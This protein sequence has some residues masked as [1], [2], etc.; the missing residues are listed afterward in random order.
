[1]GSDALTT[2]LVACKTDGCGA[3]FCSNTRWAY[4]RNEG[5]SSRFILEGLIP[6]GACPIC[7]QRPSA[8]STPSEGE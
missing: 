7:R 5:T 2:V 3:R 8:P 6:A 4:G 1:M